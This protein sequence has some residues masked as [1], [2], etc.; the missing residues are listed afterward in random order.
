M[1]ENLIG[2]EK[3]KNALSE[4]IE[5][6]NIAHSYIFT[7]IQ[8]IGKKLFAKEYAKKIMCI[9][10]DNCNNTCDS[11][12]KFDAGSN[13][14]YTEIEPD[15]K[16]IKIKQIREMQEKILEKPIISNRKVYIIN[17]A[18]SMNEE[19][20]NCLLKTLEEPPKYAIIILI[21]S[22]ENKL[23]AT[24]KSRCI[25]VKFN[26]IS[27]EEMSNHLKD[28]SEEQITLLDGSFQNLDSIDEMKQDYEE[29]IKIVNTLKKGTIVELLE[30]A[31]VLYTKKDTI[32]NLLN[33]LNIVLLKERLLEPIEFV[34]KTKRKIIASNNYEMSIDYLLINSWKKVHNA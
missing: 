33:Y 3:V 28:L 26:K 31:E 25:T 5:S 27:N 6:K 14:D 7:G 13:P 22:N 17:D 30:S 8:G 32:Q 4:A 9:N 1:F 2:N 24:I 11:C 12:I 18:D 21:V 20:Q 29:I 34:E 16:I 19:S 23:L 10:K 15:G